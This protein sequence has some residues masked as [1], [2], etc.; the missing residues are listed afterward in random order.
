MLAFEADIVADVAPTNKQPPVG[1]RGCCPEQKRLKPTW[2]GGNRAACRI[3]QA[4]IVGVG[5]KYHFAGRQQRACN[6]TTG[7][8]WTVDHWPFSEGSDCARTIEAPA[9]INH[10]T[11]AVEA[12]AAARTGGR[13]TVAI[14][15]SSCRWPGYAGTGDR[16]LHFPGRNRLPRAQIVPQARTPGILSIGWE[17]LGQVG[18]SW[19]TGLAG[20]SRNHSSG[21]TKSPE[22]IGS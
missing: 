15:T 3:P 4:Q 19:T 20:R 1:R 9:P 2:G 14:G 17:K 18:Q 16:Q 13:A 5:I 12:S 6:E 7:H 11:A 21:R 10:H 8:V 22:L